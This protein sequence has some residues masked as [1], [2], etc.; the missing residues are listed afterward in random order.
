MWECGSVGVGASVGTCTPRRTCSNSARI[1]FAAVI[2][3]YQNRLSGNMSDV[4]V[5]VGG[6]R[7]EHVSAEGGVHCRQLDW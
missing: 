3:A 2:W 7:I 6:E 4:V 5:V 1:F